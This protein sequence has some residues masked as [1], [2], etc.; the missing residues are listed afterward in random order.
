MRLLTYMKKFLLVLVFIVSFTN[1]IAQ[2]SEVGFTTGGTFYI[3]DLNNSNLFN[4]VQPAFGIV[5]RYNFDT[6]LAM[7]GTLLHGAVQSHDLFKPE[8]ELNFSST[9][10]EFSIQFEMN[11][12]NYFTGSSR[13]FISPYLFGGVGVFMF[14]PTATYF[15]EV[16][17]LRDHNTEGLEYSNFSLTLPFGIGVKYSVSRVIGLSLEWGMR[18]TITDHL[19]DVSTVYSDATTG[20]FDN[21]VPLPPHDPSGLFSAGMQRGNSK[22]N[23]WYSYAGATITFMV[24]FRGRARCDEPHRLRL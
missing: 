13:S 2:R 20:S 1:L 15:G 17:N 4:A 24:D 5:Y 8:R 11:F 3:G 16:Y 12:L 19:D 21:P 9:I 22:D 18:K 6:R 7:R 23:D 14:E 10:N